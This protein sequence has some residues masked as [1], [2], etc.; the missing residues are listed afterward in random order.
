MA[1]YCI[2]IVSK[3][4]QLQNIFSIFFGLL[5]SNLLWV[6]ILIMIRLVILGS[7]QTLCKR[8]NTESCCCCIRRRGYLN[9]ILLSNWSE[10]EGRKDKRQ[11]VDVVFHFPF[12]FN[13]L[14]TFLSLYMQFIIEISEFYKKLKMANALTFE[15][16]FFGGG[17]C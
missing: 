9:Q 16:L 12:C 13:Y 11:K 17:G 8:G 10:E 7:F 3:V 6:V 1:C 14:H 2:F 4:Y 15:T 5:K